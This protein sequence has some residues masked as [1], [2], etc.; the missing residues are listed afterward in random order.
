VVLP[1]VA[2]VVANAGRETITGQSVRFNSRAIG[3]GKDQSKDLA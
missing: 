2:V 1:Y 3:A